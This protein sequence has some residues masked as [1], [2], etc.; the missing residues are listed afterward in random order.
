MSSNYNM[1]PRPAIAMVKD[2]RARLI[3]KR[4]TYKDLM[5]LDVI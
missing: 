3:R 5:R 4:E 1:V 2:G